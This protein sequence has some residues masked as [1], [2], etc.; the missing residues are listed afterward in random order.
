[1]TNPNFDPSVFGNSSSEELMGI[2]NSTKGKYFEYLVAEKLNAGETVGDLTLPDGYEAIIASNF[3]QPG[4]DLRIVDDLGSTA[5]YLQLKATNS[6]GYINDT[7][8]RYP[9]ITILATD[10]VADQ[11]TG[12]VLDSGIS[13]ENLREQVVSMM[14]DMDPSVIDAFLEAFSPLLPI[15]FILASE[16][17]SLSVGQKSIKYVLDCAQYRL[18]RAILASGIGAVVYALGGGWFAIPATVVS[19]AVYK[20]YRDEALAAYTFEDSTMRLKK[21]RLYQQKR[22]IEGEF[23]GLAF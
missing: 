12:L 16:G 15:V 9:D 17:Y 8:E 21:Y 23:Y 20:H 7:L 22:L 18:E 1:E 6:L 19:G 13:E 2:M 10:E 5:E 14:S 4:W 3:S 11:A